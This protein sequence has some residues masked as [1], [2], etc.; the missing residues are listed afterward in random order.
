MYPVKYIFPVLLSV[1]LTR[2]VCESWHWSIVVYAADFR[3]FLSQ[4]STNFHEILHTLF[5][6]HV[7]T[8]LKVLI[9]I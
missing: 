2:L 5:S 1:S 3:R 6:I 7:V 4:F 8:T 9:S